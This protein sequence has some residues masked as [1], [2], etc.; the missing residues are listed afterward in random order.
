MLGHA[1]SVMD[2]LAPYATTGCIPSTTSSSSPTTTIVAN[3][4]AAAGPPSPPPPFATAVSIAVAADQVAAVLADA[5]VGLEALLDAYLMR[6]TTRA[7]Q[8]ALIRAWKGI[9]HTNSNAKFLLTHKFVLIRTY[10]QPN[11]AHVL[12]TIMA[13]LAAASHGNPLPLAQPP[14]SAADKDGSGD[15]GGG[16]GRGDCGD[17]DCG[18][19][20]FNKLLLKTVLAV[21][22]VWGDAAAIRSCPYV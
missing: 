22:E 10:T 7:A 18:S 5:G 2:V 12:E 9:V 6:C 19:T 13:L 17:G 11:D 15:G 1:G 16:G 4:T 20:G 3:S 14:R 21:V 8:I